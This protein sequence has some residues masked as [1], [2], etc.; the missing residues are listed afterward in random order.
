MPYDPPIYIVILND[1]HEFH[2]QIILLC[3][4]F[5]V[6]FKKFDIKFSI[7]NRPFLGNNLFLTIGNSTGKIR[8]GTM[9]P[10]PSKETETK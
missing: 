1:Q 8:F 10:P 7:K 3:R 6:L 4:K 9:Q 2:K 5:I